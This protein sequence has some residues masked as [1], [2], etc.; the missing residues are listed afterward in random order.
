[1]QFME[2]YVDDCKNTYDFVTLEQILPTAKGVNVYIQP[3]AGHVLM[4]HQTV[5][6]GFAMALDYLA[7]QGL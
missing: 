1:M 4:L 6:A 3:S 7:S 5:T 2:I